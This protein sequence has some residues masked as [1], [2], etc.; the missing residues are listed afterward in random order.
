MFQNA[1]KTAA[2]DV[3]MNQCYDS[4]GLQ[5]LGTRPSEFFDTNYVSNVGGHCAVAFVGANCTLDPAPVWLP[6]WQ[7]DRPA[8]DAM[9]SAPILA[10]FG[11]NDSFVAPGRA[12]CG[13]R[14]ID[15]DLAAVSGA[16][17]SVTYCLDP[18]AGHRDIVRGAASDY[19]M[20]W[21]AARAGAGA[22]PAA[23][24][25]LPAQNCTQPPNEF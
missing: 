7:E 6:R 4:A 5:A 23:C 21:I 2:H 18:N 11:S 17:T 25:P 13:R 12:S 9:S 16:T 15:M 14:K 10:Y 20:K 3:M 8:I 1:K 24:P 19:V 22:E